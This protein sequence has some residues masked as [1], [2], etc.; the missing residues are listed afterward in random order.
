MR[1]FQL[2]DCCDAARFRGWIDRIAGGLLVLIGARLPM[3]R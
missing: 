3:K 2:S 1:S